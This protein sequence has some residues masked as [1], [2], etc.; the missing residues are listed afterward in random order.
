LTVSVV[1]VGDAGCKGARRLDKEDASAQGVMV[2]STKR[3][4]SS[5]HVLGVY[6]APG[7]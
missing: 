4:V 3:Y 7:T 5:E 1:S 2:N 6:K